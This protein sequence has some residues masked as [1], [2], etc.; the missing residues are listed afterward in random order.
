MKADRAVLIAMGL[1]ALYGCAHTKPQPPSNN[2]PPAAA[3]AADPVARSVNLLQAADMAK[4]SGDRASA[5]QLY[6][7]AVNL[8]PANSLAWFSLGTNYLD[9][10]DVDLAV[11]ALREALRRDPTLQ[12]AWSNLSLAYLEEFRLAARNALSGAQVTGA[13]RDALSSLLA[14]VDRVLG[15]AAMRSGSTGR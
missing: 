11:V 12:K 3:A 4:V 9:Q 13:N 5:T 2:A 15:P 6:T 14:D 7:E 8:Q 10:H 1:V